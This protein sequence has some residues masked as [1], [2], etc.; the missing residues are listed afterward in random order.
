MSAGESYLLG[1]VQTERSLEDGSIGAM[2]NVSIVAHNN[3]L[4]SFFMPASQ[5]SIKYYMYLKYVLI[6]NKHL[7]FLHD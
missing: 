5:L 4:V 3:V 7:K 6:H 2:L 1:K